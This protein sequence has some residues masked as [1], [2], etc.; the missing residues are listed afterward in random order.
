MD[1]EV[2]K[3]DF[4]QEGGIKMFKKAKKKGLILYNGI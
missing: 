4:Q 2:D 3:S 1:Q